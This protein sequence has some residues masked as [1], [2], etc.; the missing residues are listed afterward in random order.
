MAETRKPARYPVRKELV[1]EKRRE[2]KHLSGRRLVDR[3]LD[4]GNQE[5]LN[6]DETGQKRPFPIGMMAE[7]IRDA[8]YHMSDKQYYTLV[9]HFAGITVPKMKVVG[10]KFQDTDPAT[11]R[12]NLVE[13][14][15]RT[16][17][18][19][20]DYT[21]KPEPENPMDS[22]AV[23]VY[24]DK[25]SGD[26]QKIGYLSADF[27]AAHPITGEMD[28]HGHL[29]DWSHGKFNII[30]YDLSADLEEIDNRTMGRMY[31]KGLAAWTEDGTLTNPTGGCRYVRPIRA[32]GTVPDPQAAS[33]Y[34]RT[35]MDLADQM[36][37]SF[38]TYGYPEICTGMEWEFDERG[39]GTVTIET[40]EPMTV[41]MV[42]VA[43]S[44]TNYLMMDSTVGPALKRDGYIDCK[45][46]ERPF[47]PPETG[48]RL[49]ESGLAPKAPEFIPIDDGDLHPLTNKFFL[50]DLEHCGVM[51]SDGKPNAGPDESTDLG[52]GALY[53]ERACERMGINPMDETRFLMVPITDEMARNMY[54]EVPDLDPELPHSTTYDKERVLSGDFIVFSEEGLYDEKYN[55]LT[56]TSRPKPRG[57]MLDFANLYNKDSLARTGT[58]WLV[59]SGGSDK[60]A[61]N[62]VVPVSKVQQARLME[63]PRF[64]LKTEPYGFFMEPVGDEAHRDLSRGPKYD[65]GPEAGADHYV[66]LDDAVSDLTEDADALSQ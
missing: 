45:I 51:G 24:V 41:D 5:L 46:T 55:S 66:D 13:R 15:K 64:S 16:D 43:N 10:I 20:V 63:D 11:L 61:D 4:Y 35:E 48:F 25:E 58:E 21:L 18:Y 52:K 53:S 38:H 60:Y 31:D 34:I 56:D 14:N 57:Y 7:R 37:Q 17:V 54:I 49:A 6:R 36:N 26:A 30:S 42:Q 27:V 28:V 3:I 23:A 32:N 39:R 62:I 59:E 40:E 29:T 50:Y 2:L 65:D 44:F 12:K 33:D 9:H 22:N 8:D 1:N 19:E 47:L